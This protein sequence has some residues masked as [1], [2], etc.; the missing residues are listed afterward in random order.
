MGGCSS[1]NAF[2]LLAEGGCWKAIQPELLPFFPNYGH[3]ASPILINVIQFSL[4]YWEFKM[5]G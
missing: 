5:W 1:I 4:V 2:I 3:V